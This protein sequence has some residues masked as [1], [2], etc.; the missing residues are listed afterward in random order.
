MALLK[1]RA[2]G[3]TMFE[4]IAAMVLVAILTPTMSYLIS[5]TMR[6]IASTRIALDA[7][8]DAE[9]ALRNFALHI[10][11]AVEFIDD[12]IIDTTLAFKVQVSST[13]TVQYI[14]SISDM[15][16]WIGCTRE[17][18][19]QGI[20]L[21]GVIGDST[22]SGDGTTSYLSRFVYRNKNGSVLSTPKNSTIHSVELIFYLNRGSEL[23]KYNTSAVP[24][25][26][27]FRL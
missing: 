3:M 10:D 4:L 18:G 14:Y 20:L 19:S 1:K 8:E 15:N 12:S 13:D 24:G 23:Y 26:S 5:N 22:D 7:G 6:S 17:G 27:M 16:R 2:T 25:R 21:E 11:R 9:Y